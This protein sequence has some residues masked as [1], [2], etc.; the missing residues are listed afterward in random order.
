MQ[1]LG[2]LLLLASSWYIW[3]LTSNFLD[4]P[5]KNSFKAAY[6][7]LKSKAKNI[8][9]LFSK[10]FIKEA[11]SKYKEEDGVVTNKKQD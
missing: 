6:N 9:K 4:E 2:L 11:W 5:T 10:E 3:K 7:E 1:L 8:E